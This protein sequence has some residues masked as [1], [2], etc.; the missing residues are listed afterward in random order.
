MLMP[1]LG[2][3]TQILCVLVF[4]ENTQ[5]ILSIAEYSMLSFLGDLLLP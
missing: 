2:L 5:M 1:K 3:S 4:D